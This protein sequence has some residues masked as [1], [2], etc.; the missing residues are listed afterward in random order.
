VL[1]DVI[2]GLSEMLIDNNLLGDSNENFSFSYDRKTTADGHLLFDNFNT[3]FFWRDTENYQKEKRENDVIVLFLQLLSDKTQYTTNI[4]EFY[5]IIFN[6][7][8][9]IKL[10]FF[11]KKL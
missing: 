7:I 8:N 10:M 11:V 5:I 2:S 1:T 6:Y 3:S 9:I 4:I